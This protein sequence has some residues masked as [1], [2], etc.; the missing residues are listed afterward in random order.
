[1]SHVRAATPADL[2]LLAAI[3][4]AGDGLFAECFGAIDWPPAD[5]GE[6]RAA[7]PGVLL[8][9]VE[10]DGDAPAGERVVG[11][12]HV[13]ELPGGWHLDQVAVHPDHG[14]SGHGGA[15]LTA[16]ASEVSRRGGEEITLSTYADVPWNAPFYARH[17]WVE[18]ERWPSHLQAFADTEERMQLTRHG[19]RTVMSRQVGSPPT[20]G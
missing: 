12:A 13:L 5:A 9:A 1:M 3:E 11:F 18:L 15:L 16:I 6:D 4:D 20:T 19:R 7:E 2:P 8:V 14:R 17:G 10:P